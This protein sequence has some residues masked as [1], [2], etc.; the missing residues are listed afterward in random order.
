MLGKEIVEAL[1]R[2]TLEMRYKNVDIKIIK[3]FDEIVANMANNLQEKLAEVIFENVG[4]T[5]IIELVKTGQKIKV[6]PNA[7]IIERSKLRFRDKNIWQMKRNHKEG[8]HQIARVDSFYDENSKR[9]IKTKTY[10][11]NKLLTAYKRDS[12]EFTRE[13][14]K[15]LVSYKFSGSQIAKFI[16]ETEEIDLVT[17]MVNEKTFN[18]RQ[19]EN[20]HTYFTD[21]KNRP[22]I[23]EH[24]KKLGNRTREEIKAN[25]KKTDC[26][27]FG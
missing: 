15:I 23:T 12:Y 2:M 21:D 22:E 25:P 1:C 6:D 16:G 24:M 9:M 18:Q 27:C 17:M 8:I 3:N 5:P 7:P 4:Q 10:I 14:L 13:I 11:N 19:L 20:I 26:F